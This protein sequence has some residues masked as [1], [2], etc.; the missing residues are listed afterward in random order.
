M[1]YRF[2]TENA[3]IELLHDK[4]QE[5]HVE[6]D[7]QPIQI[8][9]LSTVVTADTIP[10]AP[11]GGTGGGIGTTLTDLSNLLIDL[12]NLSQDN[13]KT[14][15]RLADE[16]KVQAAIWWEATTNA[17]IASL[18]TAATWLDT[19][20]STVRTGIIN[21]I[22]WVSAA[23]ARIQA[24]LSGWS[25]AIWA[26]LTN[27]G[28]SVITA[29]GATWDAVTA[30][31]SDTVAAVTAALGATW[32]AVT[33]WFADTVAAVTAALG[34]TWDA[35]TAWFVDTG[36]AVA[37]A[38][39]AAWTAV[40]NF[41]SDLAGNIADALGATWDAVTA[42]F[43]NT[44]AAVTNALGATWVAVT[45]FFA[46]TTAAIEA[47]LGATWVAVTAWFADTTAAV[48]AAL[49]ATWMAVT[50]FFADTT[51]AIEAAIGATWVWLKNL[52]TTAEGKI[53]SLVAW[54]SDVVRDSID[55]TRTWV[56][57]ASVNVL[58]ILGAT[59][60]WIDDN[61]SNI[62]RIL[63][64]I[65]A[66]NPVLDTVGGW[67]DSIH[68]L[69]GDSAS[70][71]TDG[72]HGSIDVGMHDLYNVDRIF[73]A[74]D[75][76]L[77]VTSSKPQIS[78]VNDNLLSYV[79]LSHNF[80][81]W[82]G[83]TVA[84][85]MNQF[86]ITMYKAIF[87]NNSNTTFT[88]NSNGWMWRDASG[89][90]LVR[91]GGNVLSMSD[92]GT[93]SGGGPPTLDQIQAAIHMAPESNDITELDRFIIE[94]GSILRRI[95]VN[96]VYD[97]I[98]PFGM[99]SFIIGVSNIGS[100]AVDVDNDQMIINDVDND[101]NYVRR[102]T[103]HN[104]VKAVFRR[105]TAVPPTT[106]DTILFRDVNNSDALHMTTI[107]KVLNLSTGG[108]ALTEEAIAGV[109]SGVN[110]IDQTNTPTAWGITADYIPVILSATDMAQVTPSSLFLKVFANV[111]G[112]DTPD[113]TDRVL[114]SNSLFTELKSSPFSAFGG[115]FDG[116]NRQLSNLDN[117]QINTPL[118]F[119]SISLIGFT[120]F[121][122]IHVSEFDFYFNVP[123]REIF[124][125]QFGGTTGLEL[126]DNGL[127]IPKFDGDSSIDNGGI[128][129]DT[130]EDRFKIKEDGSTVY[131]TG[132]TG[133]G[134][135]VN[136]SNL[137]SVQINS[138]LV[139]QPAVDTTGSNTATNIGA[140]AL[141]HMYFKVP[142]TDR[143]YFQVNGV[144]V[145]ELRDNGM[146]V[147]RFDGG[148]A[149]GNGGIWYD[150]GE[151]KFKV[152]EDGNTFYLTSQGVGG[153]ANRAL[154]NLASVAINDALTFD[155]T[156]N[157]VGDSAKTSIGADTNSHLYLKVPAGDRFYFQVGGFTKLELRT[158]RMKIVGVSAD[159]TSSVDNANIWYNTTEGRFK[160]REGGNTV[161]L[162]SSVGGTY[163]DSDVQD[164][165]NSLSTT[166][167]PTTNDHLAWRDGGTWKRNTI[168]TIVGL[169]PLA[170]RL[171]TLVSGLSDATPD[172][173]T[174]V[175]LYYDSDGSD[176]NGAT[177]HQ[178]FTAEFAHADTGTPVGGNH[179]VFENS[180]GFPRRATIT[181]ILALGGTGG[182]YGDSD[183]ADWLNGLSTSS[184]PTASD[185][186]IWRD[187][188]GSWRRDSI[189]DILALGG[190][191]TAGA[192]TSLSNLSSVQINEALIF[193][194]SS[195]TVGSS[196]V[197]SIGASIDGDL[198]LKVPDNEFLY[199]QIG[200][201]TVFE[202]RE[203]GIKIPNV[204]GAST[205]GNGGI[206]YDT[207]ENRFK[208]K[209]D[210]GTHYLTGGGSTY[211]DSDVEGWLNGLSTSFT[212]TT[213][214][215][216]I[217]RDS[218][219]SW[220]RDT[221][222]TVLALYPLASRLATL[223]T[224]ISQDTA[225]VNN[226]ILYYDASGSL[227][228]TSIHRI[229]TAEFQQSSPETPTGDSR[230]I[231]GSSSNFPRR[232]TI[233]EIVAAGGGGGGI[234]EDDLENLIE[235]MTPSSSIA[236]GVEFVLRAGNA[237]FK[238][239]PEAIVRT[240]LNTA[241]DPYMN[242]LTVISQSDLEHDMDY[243]LV[244]DDD[245]T[246]AH[247][248][249][250]HPYNLVADVLL[251]SQRATPPNAE[252][253]VIWLSAAGLRKV[254]INQ[255]PIVGT[256]TPATVASALYT[257]LSSVGSPLSGD[258]L[259]IS[260]HRFLVQHGTGLRTTEA[261]NI[262]HSLLRVLPN[263][264]GDD[265]AL[266]DFMIFGDTNDGGDAKRT[267]IQEILDLDAGVTVSR[268][269]S[270]IDG[271]T[272]I[273]GANL[274]V[275]SAAT[276]DYLLIRDSS[277]NSTP[278]RKISPLELV[279]SLYR[280][281]AEY[282]A[283]SF[284]FSTDEVLVFHDH[285]NEVRRTVISNIQGSGTVN[286][287]SIAGVLENV[288][289]ITAI[290][291][292]FPTIP[293]II[294]ENDMARI[295]PRNIIYHVFRTSNHL[296][297][298]IGSETG[299]VLMMNNLY[300]TV[301]DVPVSAFLTFDSTGFFNFVDSDLGTLQFVDHQSWLYNV[302]IPVADSWTA[303]AVYRVSVTTLFYN[304]IR[305]AEERTTST[306]RTND[307][308]WLTRGSSP[309]RKVT[310]GTL[311]S[312]LGLSGGITVDALDGMFENLLSDSG[313]PNNDDE[314]LYYN[315][316][317]SQVRK[318]LISEL[319]GGSLTVSGLE[320]VV[321]DI[322]T[323]TSPNDS[324]YAVVHTG[325]A[326]RRVRLD[327][328]PGG[329]GGGGDDLTVIGLEA[330]VDDIL[331]DSSPA[332]SWYAVVHTGTAMR[333][334]QLSD[335]PGGGGFSPGDDITAGDLTV[336]GN[337]E[338][339]GSG[340]GFYDTN[341]VSQNS[342][343]LPSGTSTTRTMISDSN[344]PS[345]L[346]LQNVDQAFLEVYASLNAVIEELRRMGLFG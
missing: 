83:N 94:D 26:G 166:A 89:N 130:D 279:E 90:V 317:T 162:T 174:D 1:S 64:Q 323:T 260:N 246:S 292:G 230:M 336:T 185:H 287:S 121:N 249:R 108:G 262:M 133:A 220:R 173:A 346:T 211:G 66:G 331:P 238:T 139:F 169:Y 152:K 163:G 151:E 281:G 53:D 202:L 265:P 11:K 232:A 47:A 105:T 333:R 126:H 311:V 14:V 137:S 187:N 188:N 280:G 99:Y 85:A 283:A 326:M 313:S 296:D 125:F 221:L 138:P 9:G 165:L 233:T 307:M 40:T 68:A 170:S 186:L 131:M 310:I 102:V 142:I 205:I 120:T 192:N 29:L 198:Y 250:I 197:T 291:A 101:P 334:V 33:D 327:D 266:G 78:G 276:P 252:N 231:F 12:Q 321:D 263:G 43:A 302:F 45:T 303:N 269:Q 338:H 278:I 248:K 116:A 206:W 155:T 340:L 34:A 147:P 164:F 290:S 61:I 190:T 235:T 257:W 86:G 207:D 213:G 3:E 6:I 316:G 71:N 284:D 178:I 293:I 171:A 222:D 62:Q 193:D 65:T 4:I 153:G 92:I 304:I 224:G 140:A 243:L 82:V 57:N 254:K 38:L 322:I 312:Y 117:V 226:D 314:F 227:G 255:L 97:Y 242:S 134:A 195:S 10:I 241:V 141:G 288:N 30:W 217:W 128:W 88:G 52:Y 196:N 215:H 69:W 201:T 31:F 306:L 91:S 27:F 135:N 183:V 48:T 123:T 23:A 286:E 95:D 212:P 2:N 93:G 177:V 109:L 114:L 301:F 87:I 22:D 104:L 273:D 270:F 225:S 46:D 325:T 63:G 261:R 343:N 35:V 136:L 55:A 245:A 20:T 19:F 148:S 218:N 36:A 84:M 175:F 15:T 60:T 256:I 179:M 176:I 251:S 161:Y 219:G 342:W 267:T 50:A 216:L 160:G 21:T 318:A 294:S 180:S 37:A 24:V 143:F 210:G 305:N 159:P 112:D 300:N 268:M 297:H 13:W 289:E 223:V 80:A 67:L 272:V 203:N 146:I 145:L 189:S 172:H 214:D 59:W 191:G 309:D 157:T 298:L 184:T 72:A 8:P 127:I 204:D 7:S 194:T 168:G 341:P 234:T 209:E 208:A 236:S 41:F 111:T 5:L 42:W 295:S 253:D 107:E 285:S 158:D 132:G 154:S 271:R 264:T 330:I 149:I 181:D 96:T 76:N 228:T 277:S 144:T 240:G 328:L 239:G 74:S 118:V 113:D 18:K 324:W 319:P 258:D 100:G 244:Q 345:S 237:L 247:I 16:V 75:D 329:V 182:T 17:V 150:T 282:E 106:D 308:V 79:Q 335:L 122:N 274:A 299:R 39:G 103:P 32:N 199:F 200:G 51:A 56:I 339:T 73:F 81:W 156:I 320:G 49:G 315:S 28:A 229:F 98:S 119:Q 44:V 124:Y 259:Q 54:Y 70:I 110:T 58:T 275:Y 129:Y 332:N 25:E 115:T 337:L 344:I 167:T 77:D